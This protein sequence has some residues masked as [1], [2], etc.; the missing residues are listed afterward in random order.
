MPYSIPA[1]VIDFQCK[2]DKKYTQSLND[3][4]SA[5]AEAVS[6][7]LRTPPWYPPYVVPAS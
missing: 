3:Q 4:G 5:Q 7:T 1:T 2:F 6:V